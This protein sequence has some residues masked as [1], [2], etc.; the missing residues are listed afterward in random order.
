V[1]SDGDISP[2]TAWEQEIETHLH[3]AHIILLLI[4]PDFLH[5]DYCYS[6]EMIYAI[7][8]HQKKDARVIPVLLR[9]VDWT[10]T[11]FSVL[12]MLPSNTQPI[13]TWPDRDVAFE[14]VAK[15]I[16]QVVNELLF[17]NRVT[18]KPPVPVEQPSS[19][20]PKNQS[21]QLQSTR[22]LLIGSRPVS[23]MQKNF[24]AHSIILGV[25]FLSF[26]IQ[27]PDLALMVF[28]F[29]ILFLIFSVA[30][31]AASKKEALTLF[32]EGFILHP[33]CIA[34]KHT[35]Q[36]E[37]ISDIK[38]IPHSSGKVTLSI[39]S[40]NKY[41][42]YKIEISNNFEDPPQ[43]SQEILDAYMRFKKAH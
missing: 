40:I 3:Y 14:D 15:G 39:E 29:W 34:G 27:F 11:P 20:R 24:L 36:Y 22:R 12:Q 28:Y 5:S 4:S 31:W 26:L 32:S 13:T 21:I 19:V 37:E 16:R 25:F 6:K 8:R 38:V 9:P 7:K 2:G 35:I 42:T 1:W 23:Y 18:P 30:D 43:L 33:D 41:W 17:P 10:N